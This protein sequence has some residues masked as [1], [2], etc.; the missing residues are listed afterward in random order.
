M[1]GLQLEASILINTGI[2]AFCQALQENN[3][4]TFLAE[5][6]TITSFV[7]HF[8][9][10]IELIVLITVVFINNKSIE[11]RIKQN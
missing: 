10:Q 8:C 1:F 3:A 2:H 11:G 5:L 9:R 4:I 6:K 7:L